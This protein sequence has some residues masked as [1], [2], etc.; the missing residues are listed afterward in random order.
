MSATELISRLV[1]AAIISV[2]A[3]LR[4]KKSPPR[5]RN[6]V[7]PER[8]LPWSSYLNNN[9]ERMDIKGRWCVYRLFNSIRIVTS[10]DYLTCLRL[11][12]TRLTLNQVTYAEVYAYFLISLNVSL[13][14]FLCDVLVAVRSLQAVRS[15]PVR[16]S[17]V[18]RFHTWHT[19]LIKSQ[20]TRFSRSYRES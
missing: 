4:A 17:G 19:S 6:P 1:S 8:Q 13:S 7:V 5:E 10:K 2:S 3:L 20:E 15:M 16:N 14:S 12:V 9:G 11:S 18:P